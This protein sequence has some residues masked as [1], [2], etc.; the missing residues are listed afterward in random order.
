VMKSA[1]PDNPT[2][3]QSV[4]DIDPMSPWLQEPIVVYFHS[5]TGA[6]YRRCYFS[7]A[8]A[9]KA[10]RK[11]EAAGRPARMYLCKLVPVSPQPWGESE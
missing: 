4:N 9:A 11:A 7:V 8:S 10:L 3:P 1:G 6:T 5:Q 2:V